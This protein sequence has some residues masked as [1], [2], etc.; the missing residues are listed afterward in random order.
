LVYLPIP[1]KNDGVKVSDDE[2][3]NIWKVIKAMFQTTNQIVDDS[4]FQIAIFAGYGCGIPAT[5]TTLWDA[6][7]PRGLLISKSKL[8]HRCWGCPEEPNI[9]N[10]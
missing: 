7:E 5:T 2:I 1:L 9:T 4:G 6:P 3:P 8:R 10:Q